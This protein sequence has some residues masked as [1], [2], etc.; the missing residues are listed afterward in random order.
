MQI[1]LG[2]PGSGKTTELLGRVLERTNPSNGGLGKRVW[3]VGLP[4]QRP[5]VMRRLT[6]QA[7]VAM[8][9]EFMS[10]QQL[11]MRLLTVN[12]IAYPP[13]PNTERIAVVGR[14]IALSDDQPIP[15]PGEANLYAAAIAE[16][17]RHNLGPGDVDVGELKTPEGYREVF[18]GTVDALERAHAFPATVER[19][20]ETFKRY[21]IL[22]HELGK[23]DY[24]DYRI[25]ARHILDTLDEV[26]VEP[27]MIVVDGFRTFTPLE[28]SIFAAL[29]KHVEV[30][31][32]CNRLPDGYDASE[33]LEARDAT[34]VTHQAD[35]PIDE[36]RF[37]L[38]S[39]KKDVADGIDP[40]EVALI[41]PE[42]DH[43]F[44]LTLAREYGVPLMPASS[45]SLSR[46]APGSL[47]MD[48]LT[49]QDAPNPSKLERLP[50]LA[51]LAITTRREGL[52]G[53]MG[54][55]FIAERLGVLDLYRSWL[56][57]LEAPDRD[58]ASSE[59]VTELRERVFRWAATLIEALPEI[60]P[61]ACRE[62]WDIFKEMLLL[63]AR[64]AT[65]LGF[66]GQHYRR[67]LISLIRD[68]PVPTINN[69][70]V[71][72]LSA[73]QASGVQ[74]Q[75]AYVTNAIVGAYTLREREDF[76]ITEEWRGPDG[77]LDYYLP[78]RFQGMDDLLYAELRSRAPE[79]T[80]SFAAADQN[81]QYQPEPLLTGDPAGAVSLPVLPAASRVELLGF[82][83]FQADTTFPVEDLPRTVQA[84]K[85]FMDCP[86]K[87]WGNKH[88][89]DDEPDWWR[90]VV[91]SLTQ[92][93][94]EITQEI[95]DD[96]KDEHPLVAPW[97]DEN[98]HELLGYKFGV[99]MPKAA[100]A[101][102]MTAVVD[103]ARFDKGGHV[104]IV[105]F[106]EPGKVNDGKEANRAI[107]DRWNELYATGVLF[108]QH[109]NVV[110]RVDIIVWP[111]LGEPIQAYTFRNLSGQAA[112]KL[113]LVRSAV[114]A[115]EEAKFIAKPGFYCRYCN[116]ASVCRKDAA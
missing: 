18:G 6:E 94:G 104:T 93:Q 98:A 37:T 95:L 101:G 78:K 58:P 109:Q 36:L 30:I 67:W 70:A 115:L 100:A 108:E 48:L 90:Q 72:L 75:R 87:Y 12:G 49:Y 55:E 111:I 77:E 84:L 64:E 52:T 112:A 23:F 63:R 25:H 43:P 71:A 19:F 39:I 92:H 27:D 3:W 40:L 4:H 65:H 35:N 74:F 46:T 42:R 11:Y 54:V 106:V 89:R 7:P 57:R 116:F 68:T 83:P 88:L 82:T 20:R 17:K 114:P 29:S 56:E 103:A 91:R 99:R 21:E 28:L 14:A 107:Y 85:S 10:T 8:G 45:K 53:L 60:D 15:G 33:T 66:G 44:I 38:R 16:A 41:A 26:K 97:I 80:I 69:G 86:V 5:H 79:V 34:V 113:E 61:E 47:M 76:F 96:L 24:D 73:N 59:T 105:H 31:V 50:G 81:A 110:K 32:A 9:V 1:L 102:E 13:M 22:K 51:E 62:G 2:P